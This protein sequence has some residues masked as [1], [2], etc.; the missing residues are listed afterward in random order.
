MRAPV[1]R[2]R[3]RPS[4]RS[5]TWES[6]DD[7]APAGHAVGRDAAAGADRARARPHLQLRTDGLRPD[8]HRQLPLV[9]VRGS[10]RPVPALPGPRVTWVMNITDIDDRIIERA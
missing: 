7:P 6:I 9:P 1:D 10:P 8:A 2:S 5:G 4:Q 3:R